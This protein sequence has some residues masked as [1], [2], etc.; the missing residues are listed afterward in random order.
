MS[1]YK[2]GVVMSVK[3]KW[4]LWRID[5]WEQWKIAV[6]LDVGEKPLKDE[7]KNVKI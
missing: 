7:E 2:K 4:L 3:W 6:E 1:A 5:T